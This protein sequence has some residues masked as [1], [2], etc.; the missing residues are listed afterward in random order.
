MDESN[1]EL[2]LEINRLERELDAKRIALKNTARIYNDLAEEHRKRVA[3]ND[4]L[5]AEVL[6][7]NGIIDARDVEI[8]VLKRD[9][10]NWERNSHEAGELYC[11]L[12]K[13]C[14]EKDAE[15][16][17]LKKDCERYQRYLD[18][19]QELSQEKDAEITRLKA[20]LYD[21]LRKELCK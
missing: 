13:E 21:Y 17:E 3:E 6:K 2:I 1:Q 15:I 11:E 7:L 14:A 4:L 12:E 19:E 18:G 8:E 20:E 9:C 5:K 10:E 16:K